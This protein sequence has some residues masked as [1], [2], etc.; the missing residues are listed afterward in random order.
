[1]QSPEGWSWRSTGAIV[2]ARCLPVEGNSLPHVA[3]LVD[4]YSVESLDERVLTTACF[5]DRSRVCVVSLHAELEGS[6]ASSSQGRTRARFPVDERTPGLRQLVVDI[7]T[8]IERLQHSKAA[9]ESIRRSTS[10]MEWL[11]YAQI[12]VLRVHSRHGGRTTL[13]KAAGYDGSTSGLVKDIAHWKR[14]SR[15]HVLFTFT[16]M[17]TPRMWMQELAW[18]LVSNFIHIALRR[19]FV[20]EVMFDTIP[21]NHPIIAHIRVA[22]HAELILSPTIRGPP[23]VFRVRQHGELMSRGVALTDGTC[24]F[25]VSHTRGVVT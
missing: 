13:A 20:R 4:E 25:G 11:P 5:V 6:G 15:G 12:H 8:L 23:V 21:A 18:L 16:E 14:I 17:T 19:Q 7:A 3:R 10:H 2:C 1:M 22:E 24:Q 9:W